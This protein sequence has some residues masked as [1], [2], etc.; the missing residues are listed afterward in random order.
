MTKYVWE[1]C[2]LK[3][4][5]NCPSEMQSYQQLAK[6]LRRVLKPDLKDEVEKKKKNIIKV[7]I[8]CYYFYI[9]S[10]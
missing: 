7:L 1:S 2:L 8:L 6:Y 9:I 3:E 5:G 10:T 4:T